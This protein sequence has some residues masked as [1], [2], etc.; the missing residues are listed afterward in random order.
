MEK[1]KFFRVFYWEN[2]DACKLIAD[3]ESYSTI[4][5]HIESANE[6]MNWMIHKCPYKEFHVDGITISLSEEEANRG[7][8]TSQY[9]NG[10]VKIFA[11]LINRNKYMGGIQWAF[12]KHFE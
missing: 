11:A 2:I 10:Y 6:S 12:K 1:D 3:V 9:P 7:Q 4:R 5:Q 8:M